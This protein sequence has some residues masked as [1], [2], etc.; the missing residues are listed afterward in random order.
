MLEINDN[1]IVIYYLVTTTS[2]DHLKLW[3][4]NLCTHTDY[5]IDDDGGEATNMNY[6]SPFP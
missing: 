3:N 5:G 2:H 1:G 4:K 6:F